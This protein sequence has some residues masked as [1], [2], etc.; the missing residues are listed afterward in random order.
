MTV[1]G[2]ARFGDVRRIVGEALA[3]K[4]NASVSTVPA[5]GARDHGDRLGC[6]GTVG[7]TVFLVGGQWVSTLKASASLAQAAKY[8]ELKDRQPAA[9]TGSYLILPWATIES[10]SLWVTV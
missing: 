7:G 1:T 9:R 4:L 3:A 5:V 2:H 10:P 6:A 8:P